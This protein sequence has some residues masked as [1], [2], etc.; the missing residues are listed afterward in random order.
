[1]G[2]KQFTLY[3]THT[4]KFDI[5]AVLT[6]FSMA[7]T[8]SD[9]WKISTHWEQF[10]QGWMSNWASKPTW[11]C[12]LHTLHDQAGKGEAKP[13]P[14]RDQQEPSQRSLHSGTPS[15]TICISALSLKLFQRGHHHHPL[16][17]TSQVILSNNIIIIEFITAN[18]E[19]HTVQKKKCLRPIRKNKKKQD[20][21][22]LIPGNILIG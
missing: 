5:C 1:M 14:S 13:N 11:Y 16:S 2:P 3:D 7:T 21:C 22:G 17:W 18:A 6:K 15:L 10:C 12:G 20:T 19:S 4:I 9:A 8:S